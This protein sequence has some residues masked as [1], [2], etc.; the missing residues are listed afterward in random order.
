M[1]S[2]VWRFK[3]S[4]AA[5]AASAAL[6]ALPGAPA[7]AYDRIP[8][9]AIAVT[10]AVVHLVASPEISGIRYLLLGT[11]LHYGLVLSPTQTL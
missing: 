5:P 2:M 10:T 3:G 8:E 6:A 4:L 7:S 1:H 11:S 9:E